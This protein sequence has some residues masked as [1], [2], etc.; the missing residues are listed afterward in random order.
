MRILSIIVFLVF[1]SGCS[2]QS[3]QLSAVMDLI[4][5]PAS[6]V[7]LNGWSVKYAEYEAIVYPVNT[8]QGTLFSNQMG[9]QVLFDG[10]SVDVLA[11][12]VCEGRPIKTVILL[13]SEPLCV[14]VDHWPCINVI[15]GNKN[16][17]LEKS[18]F[19]NPAK[20]IAFILITFLLSKT[21][22]FL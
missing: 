15:S 2:V 5:K 20:V 17:N 11:V 8:S 13:C 1:L 12:W 9:D 3:S 4:K 6:D 19:L 7:L 21:A 16:S 14:A 10:W 18:N 22:V